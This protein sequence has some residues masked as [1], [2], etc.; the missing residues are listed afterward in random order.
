L[1]DHPAKSLRARL[2]IKGLPG[3]LPLLVAR[4]C[5]IKTGTSR[6]SERRYQP[7]A[8]MSIVRRSIESVSLPL[9]TGQIVDF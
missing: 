2:G 7:D 6:T 4:G 5:S 9:D 3:T 1:A 8:K